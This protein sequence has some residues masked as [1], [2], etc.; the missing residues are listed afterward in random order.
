MLWKNQSFAKTGSGQTN[1]KENAQEKTA[2]RPQFAPGAVAA[3]EAVKVAEGG[4]QMAYSQ[5]YTQVQTVTVLQGDQVHCTALTH[6]LS[7][8]WCCCSVLLFLPLLLL[9]LLLGCYLCGY[10]MFVVVAS[11]LC[12]SSGVLLRSAWHA[13]SLSRYNRPPPALHCSTL[14][15]PSILHC[16]VLSCAS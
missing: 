7:R 6:S 3:A 2:Y 4:E 13:W 5:V 10:I 14:P 15:F 8:C 16:C 9:L 1:A 12:G 11:R